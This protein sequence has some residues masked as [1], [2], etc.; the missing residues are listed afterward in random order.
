MYNDKEEREEWE[1]WDE[2]DV[3]CCPACNQFI[4]SPAGK[5]ENWMIFLVGV[6]AFMLMIAM[7]LPAWRF[8]AH[9]TT[10]LEKKYEFRGFPHK[11]YGVL[12]IKGTYS[13]AWATQAQAACDLRDLGTGLAIIEFAAKETLGRLPGVS[14]IT[15]GPCASSEECNIAFTNHAIARCLQYE[16]M[17]KLSYVV[18]TFTF[19]GIIMLFGGVIA[20]FLSKRRITGGIAVGLWLW[21]ALLPLGSG[22]AWAFVTD[23]AFQTLAQSAWYPYPSLHYAFYIYVCGALII[24]VANGVFAAM[25][26][27]S[28][29]KYDKATEKLEKKQR[30][31]ER[32]VE[33]DKNAILRQE[34]LEQ[35]KKQAQGVSAK[36]KGGFNFPPPPGMK[37]GKGM[38]GGPPPYGGKGGY[39]PPQQ[40]PPQ[41]HYP[42]QQQYPAQQQYPPQQQYPQQQYPPQNGWGGY[43]AQQYGQQQMQQENQG[44]IANAQVAP[45]AG[46]DFGI[47]GAQQP[48]QQQTAPQQPQGGYWPAAPHQNALGELPAQP[49]QPRGPR[50][51][52]KPMT[53]PGGGG[54]MKRFSRFSMKLQQGWNSMPGPPPA[55]RPQR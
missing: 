37:G 5:P 53:Q 40:Y 25:V 45:T 41:Q 17:S 31:L 10:E 8:D 2:D 48:P 35:L 36:G 23:S 16:R 52:Q 42:P 14:Y 1:D 29:W 49:T 27:P 34:K 21:G 11:Y 54:M 7:L 39:P 18:M 26:C 55:T 19:I 51:P 24:L 43:D 33:R 13:K 28:V 9:G 44:L 50:P 6:G 47:G 38:K 12:H 46:A 4:N 20:V 15:G 22:I 3:C 32:K 30:K